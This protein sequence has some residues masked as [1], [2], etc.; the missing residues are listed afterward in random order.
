MQAV[1][2]DMQIPPPEHTLGAPSQPPV[3]AA[4]PPESVPANLA[5]LPRRLELEVP[6][7]VLERLELLSERSDRSID[8]L[9][10]EL[11]DRGLQRDLN[12]KGPSS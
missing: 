4:M 12:E 9:A 10:M 8:E 1:T 3:V 5:E 7:P 6:P 2:R 11:I